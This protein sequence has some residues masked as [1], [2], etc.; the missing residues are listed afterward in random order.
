ML[1]GFIFCFVLDPRKRFLDRFV[2]KIS[3]VPFYIPSISVC[4][5]FIDVFG[6]DSLYS[7]ILKLFSIN[8][9]E[10]LFLYSGT[11]IVIAHIFMN[12]TY[13]LQ[14]FYQKRQSIPKDYYIKSQSL[15]MS[16]FQIFKYI[17]WNSIKSEI[18]NTWLTVFILCLTSFT[19]VFILG[20][21]LQETKTIEVSIYE[22]LKF[23]GDTS[24]A[25][26]LLILQRT[27][28]LFLAILRSRFDK[29]KVMVSTQESAKVLIDSLALRIPFNLLILILFYFIG[30]LIFVPFIQ[31][32][33]SFR[34]FADSQFWQSITYS[35]TIASI[36]AFAT[37]LLSTFI[38]LQKK[39]KQLTDSITFLL[40]SLS[41]MSLAFAW[42]VLLFDTQIEHSMVSP[43]VLIFLH[44]LY[45]TPFALQYL[46]PAVNSFI[47]TFSF[48]KSHLNIGHFQFFKLAAKTLNKTYLTCFI[49]TFAFSIGESSASFMLQTDSFTPLSVY[50]YEL[51][52]RYRFQEASVAALMICIIPWF[53][54]ILS[55]KRVY[56]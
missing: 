37:T 50:L 28:C 18:L 26:S 43:L 31:F 23:D 15:N 5:L 52:G 3:S 6:S 41:P 49:F 8:P 40:L 17:E 25:T 9:P 14:K 13:C 24:L 33:A 27:L 11:S 29:S 54:L 45:F 39:S 47:D 12:A 35:F 7:K 36:T 44:I 34:L 51:M 42:Q 46:S 10:K 2:L 20:G 30:H 4:F 55:E 53:A 56:K 22:S 19:T 16:T 38:L 21:G 1:L 48:Q 32:E